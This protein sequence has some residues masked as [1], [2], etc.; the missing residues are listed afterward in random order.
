[1]HMHITHLRSLENKRF[2]S[3]IKSHFIIPRT[4]DLIAIQKFE[5]TALKCIIFRFLYWKH[6]DT[7]TISP[8]VKC[9]FTPDRYALETIKDGLMSTQEKT[10]LNR[11]TR[12]KS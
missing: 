1:M 8:F 6:L 12:D 11:Q 2:T 5:T 7:F 3:I 4:K 9:V 10:L